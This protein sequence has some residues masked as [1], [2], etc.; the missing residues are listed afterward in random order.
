MGMVG[1]ADSPERITNAMMNDFVTMIAG[2]NHCNWLMEARYRGKD[3]LPALR[4]T[5]E[6]LAAGESQADGDSKHL[7]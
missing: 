5:V 4:R 7:Y 6:R 2:V 3:G 1:I